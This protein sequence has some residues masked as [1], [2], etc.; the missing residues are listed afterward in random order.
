MNNNL[1][2]PAVTSLPSHMTTHD[3]PQ[4]LAVTLF[5]FS[6]ISVYSNF[7]QFQNIGVSL[8]PDDPGP[9]TFV[10]NILSLGDWGFNG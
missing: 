1:A 7:I 9:F 2:K 6:Y 10:A 5:L 8:A 3:I 4:F